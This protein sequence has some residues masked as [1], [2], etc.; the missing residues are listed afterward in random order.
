M[1]LHAVIPVLNEQDYLD[2][3]THSQVR[4]EY[5]EGYIFAMSGTT[6]AH[7]QIAGNLYMLIRSHTRGTRCRV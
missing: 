5:V 7:N 4:H 3:E 1:A 2:L 6:K